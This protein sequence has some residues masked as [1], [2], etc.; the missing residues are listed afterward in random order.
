MTFD[1]TVN[2]MADRGSV[3]IFIDKEYDTW[4]VGTAALEE[5]FGF[6]S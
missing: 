6:I 2:P 1:T 4:K 3:L 5:A